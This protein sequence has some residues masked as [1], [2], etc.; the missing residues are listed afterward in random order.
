MRLRTIAASLALVASGAAAH[1]QSPTVTLDSA[2]RAELLRARDRIWRAWFSN[3]TAELARLLP[4]AAASAEQGDRWADRA[5]ILAS[6]KAFAATGAKLVRIRFFDTEI[7]S[8]GNV[9]ITYARYEAET[10]ERGRRVTMKG[11]ATEVFVRRGSEWVNPFWHLD[12]PG[13]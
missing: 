2:T 9:A 10:E 12:G 11:R 7:V 13:Y 6:S 5:N 4:P 1:A 8:Y 3:D